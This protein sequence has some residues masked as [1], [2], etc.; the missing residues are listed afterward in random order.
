MTG[1]YVNLYEDINP[2]DRRGRFGGVGYLE[3][4]REMR[5]NQTRFGVLPSPPNERWTE[6]ILQDLRG[7]VLATLLSQTPQDE[8]PLRQAP[9]DASQGDPGTPYAS[10]VAAVV[11]GVR[12]QMP[13]LWGFRRAPYRDH[14][15]LLSLDSSD[16][17]ANSQTLCVTC[18]SPTGDTI[19]NY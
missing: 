5:R 4:L 11:R 8:A 10:G 2:Q 18:N 13:L 14:V 1:Q 6:V 16:S 12:R 15:I 3:N 9:A 17:I 19:D 7:G